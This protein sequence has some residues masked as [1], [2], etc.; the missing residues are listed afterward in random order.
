MPGGLRLG[1]GGVGRRNGGGVQLVNM[2]APGI[3]GTPKI[4][5]TL[6]AQPGLWSSISTISYGYRW[7]RNGTEI[8]DA[9]ATSYTLVDDDAGAALRVRVTASDGTHSVAA[10]SD[11]VTVPT[12]AVFPPVF[13]RAPSFGA[14]GYEVGE[15][16]TFDM[17]AAGPVAALSIESFTLGGL[18]RKAELSGNTWNSIGEPAGT[19][20]LRIRATNAGGTTLSAP[21]SV[22]LSFTPGM[23]VNA[24]MPSIAGIPKIG[25]TLTASTG[26]WTTNGT[27]SFAYQWLRNGSPISGAA[28]ATYTLVAADDG[29]SVSCRVT[30]TDNDGS[31]AA[32][33]NSLSVTYAAAEAAGTISDVIYTQGAGVQVVDAAS[34]FSGAVGGT[35][36][37]TG[38]GTSIDQSGQVSITTDTIR[39]ASSV[40]VSYTNSGGVETS[41]FSVTVEE[42]AGP[43]VNTV[44]PVISGTPE[45]GEALS[46]STGTWTT[47]GSVSYAYQWK[48]GGVN[49]SGATA[50]SYTLVA[51]DDGSDVSCDVTATDDGGN[52]TATTAAVN[53]TYSAPV[54]TNQPNFGT[55]S[56]EMG[57]IVTFSEGVAANATLSVETF[58]LGGVDKSGELSGTSWDTTGES[59]GT[60]AL[61]VEASNSGG[62]TLSNTI[63][64]ALSEAGASPSQFLAYASMRHISDGETPSDGLQL[65]GWQGSPTVTYYVNGSSASGSAGVFVGDTVYAEVSGTDENGNA[66]S[67]TTQTITVRDQ[68]S[69]SNATSHTFTGDAAAVAWNT[70]LPKGAFVL[71]EP[72]V[73]TS[74]ATNVTA[75]GDADGGMMDPFVDDAAAEQGF[76]SV[77]WPNLQGGN[78]AYS[79]SLDVTTGNTAVA[80]GAHTMMVLTADAPGFF[81]DAWGIFDK[82]R[83]LTFLSKAPPVG[84]FRPGMSDTAN[85]IIVTDDDIDL[86]ALRSLDV[87]G[88]SGIGTYADTL[89]AWRNPIGAFGPQGERQRRI[90]V[91]THVKSD[92]YSADL[93]TGLLIDTHVHLHSNANSAS[94]KR[95]LARMVIQAAIDLCAVAER[96]QLGSAGAGQRHF[97]GAVLMTAVCLTGSAALWAQARRY[98]WNIDQPKPVTAADIASASAW[99]HGNEGG[100]F[101]FVRP[102]TPLWAGRVLW[103]KDGNQPDDS[104]SA[105]M[106]RTYLDASGR[107]RFAELPGILAMQESSRVP[108]GPLIITN[109]ADPNVLSEAE[110]RTAVLS[111]LDNEITMYPYASEPLAGNQYISAQANQW[112]NLTRPLTAGAYPVQARIPMPPEPFTAS[113]GNLSVNWD[114]TNQY[115]VDYGSVLPLTGMDVLAAQFSGIQFESIGTALAGSVAMPPIPIYVTARLQNAEGWGE[116]SWAERDVG[117]DTVPR[118]LVTPTGSTSAAITNTAAP[119]LMR[120][121]NPTPSKMFV[122]AQD[123]EVTPFQEIAIGSGLWA[124]NIGS[125]LPTYS[126]QVETSPGSGVGTAAAGTFSS[127]SAGG[128]PEGARQYRIPAAEAG[129]RIRGGVTLG[130]VGPVY[131][132]WVTVGALPTYPAGTLINTDFGELAA[133]YHGA[134]FANAD[135]RNGTGGHVPGKGFSGFVDVGAFGVYKNASFP[136][137]TFDL[138]VPAQPGITYAVDLEYFLE[139]GQSGREFQIRVRGPSNNVMEDYGTITEGQT[140]Q[141]MT[142]SSGTRKFALK[143]TFTLPTDIFTDPQDLNL[144]IQTTSNAGGSSGGNIFISKARIVAL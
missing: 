104:N 138:A 69:T 35:W 64:V 24:A 40:A 142:W 112:W 46:V 109:G 44:L 39:A 52:T 70:S 133:A 61:R 55:S 99:A 2:T 60:I 125:A 85:E 15:I 51:G 62:T 10:L 68:I 72:F 42:A 6:T 66:A 56:Y 91:F 120:R 63:T 29:A 116:R 59:A 81:S 129:Q 23:P 102:I 73:V 20:S 36:S 135:I 121:D 87:S 37:V 139:G 48:R 127:D 136:N 49:I 30:A 17:G 118:N 126:M 9:T 86:S 75:Y 94:E 41:G 14:A 105:V 141:T 123:D 78:N 57:D 82:Y 117:S 8:A 95:E 79:A 33:S 108:S 31:A 119:K 22:A 18:D 12:A 132:P 1:Y 38:T 100:E 67:S 32:V 111:F 27:P 58:T 88:V 143:G 137:A 140:K 11:T 144:W 74:S 83:P 5:G 113:A 21:V 34:D 28:S 134:E 114:F 115:N 89:A 84:A 96:G 130:G 65:V 110:P 71:A 128:G 107:G 131:S 97:Y 76:S 13:T 98:R 122:E 124:G 101:Q 50:A 16:V 47:T 106:F 45:I 54:F 80:S 92:N 103:A 25:Q 93:S 90:D 3:E 77:T 53:V 43:P 26:T 7:L 19:L 4:G